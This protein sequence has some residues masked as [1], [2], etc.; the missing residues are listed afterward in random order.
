[1]YQR[2]FFNKRDILAFV[3]A[4]LRY[5]LVGER[6]EAEVDRIQGAALQV[7]KGHN[8][9]ELLEMGNDVYDRY[10]VSYTHLTLPTKRIV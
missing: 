2:G 4:N 1:M 5:Q 3:L 10:A 7:V 6:N 9:E 8:V